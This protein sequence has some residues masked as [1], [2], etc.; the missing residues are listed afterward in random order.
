M[1]STSRGHRTLPRLSRPYSV[2]CDQWWLIMPWVL[3]GTDMNREKKW[4][5]LFLITNNQL[6]TN[7]LELQ[8]PPLPSPY[9]VKHE[10]W[11]KK[12]SERI[13]F[14]FK[15][16]DMI[17][18]LESLDPAKPET[19]PTLHNSHSWD[20]IYIPFFFFFALK[21]FVICHFQPIEN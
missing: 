21:K 20:P 11:I 19:L 14:F 6:E 12:S 18:N 15:E 2:C 3:S 1:L 5:S 10:S 7:N 16:T 9:R 8:W 4:V 13:F 17:P